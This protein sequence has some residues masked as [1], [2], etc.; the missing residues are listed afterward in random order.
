MVSSGK[1]EDN[2]LKKMKLLTNLAE[3][4]RCVGKKYKQRKKMRKHIKNQ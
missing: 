3:I 4:N 1:V 2:A